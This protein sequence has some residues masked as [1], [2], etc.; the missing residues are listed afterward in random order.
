MEKKI[1]FVLIFAVVVL[2][3][4]YVFNYLKPSCEYSFGF[5]QRGRGCDI[6]VDDC[7]FGGCLGEVVS[8]SCEETRTICG[9]EFQC[10]C[11]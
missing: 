5:G 3:G 10:N 2:T 7:S 1:F 8:L 9:E 11:L 4:F 6:M